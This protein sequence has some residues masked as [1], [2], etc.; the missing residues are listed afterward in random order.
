MTADSITVPETDDGIRVSAVWHRYARRGDRATVRGRA[1]TVYLIALFVLIY[2]VPV[3]Y[4][5]ST[6]PA[7]IA[8]GSPAG[9]AP[10][11]WAIAVTV[12]WGAQLAGRFWGPLVIQ[13]FLLHVFTSTDIPPASYLGTI[14]RRRLAYVSTAVLLSACTATYLTTDLYRELGL[15]LQG[16]AAAAG[17]SAL[18][19]VAWLWGQVRAVPGNVLLASAAGAV[20]LAVTVIGRV[21][22]GGGGGL[23][24]VAGVLA[25]GAAVIGRTAFR[26]IP[27]IDL[28]RL[29]RE[30][31]R[32]SQAQT[33]ALTGT[34]HHA[35][36]LYRPEPRRYTSALIRTDGTLRGHLTQGA[37][38]ALRTPGRAAAAVVLLLAGGAVLTLGAAAQEGRPALVSWMAGS[39]CVYLGSGWVSETWRG[40]R[41]ELTLPPLYGERWGGVLARTLAWPV[42][43]V[44]AGTCAG[45]GLA[46]T[47]PWWPLHG[48]S[49]AGTLLLLAGSLVLVL[50]ARFLREMKLDLPL[51]LLMPIASPLGDLSGLRIVAWQFDGLVAVVAGIGLISAVPSAPG[52]TALAVAIAAWYVWSGLR[53]TGWGHRGLLTRLSRT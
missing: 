25:A 10:A 28:A 7:L 23:W 40:L 18:A 30:S 13:P 22:P 34:L 33:Y 48:E 11:A 3:V 37:I 39:V 36:D 17:L 51:E 9:A 24:L 20:A 38:R 29:A 52:A 12:C 46:L 2:L 53:R 21:A 43:A 35:L 8:V 27:A 15:A 47:T 14:A 45:S 5:A 31:A 50:A 19:A 32:A 49:A 6:S 4:T 16:L 26:S 41:D 44:T 1:Y 42:L